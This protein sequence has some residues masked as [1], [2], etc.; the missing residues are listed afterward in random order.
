MPGIRERFLQFVAAGE[1]GCLLW[2]GRR[3]SKPN[4]DY[5]EFRHADGRREGAHRVAW[6]ISN[7]PI[8]DGLFVCHHC[9]NPPCVNPAHLFLGT[10]AD[11]MRDCFAKGRHV[12]PSPVEA[13]RRLSDTDVRDIRRAVSN[14]ARYGDLAKKYSVDSNTVKDAATGK[15][16]SQLDEPTAKAPR[17]GF[18][19]R[20]LEPGQAWCFKC[21]AA[22]PCADFAPTTAQR[23]AGWCRACSSS[24]YALRRRHA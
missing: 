22:K 7:G 5:G 4:F 19:K 18:R 14:G 13:I 17:K 20:K 11:N 12:V 21:K 8:P 16:W 24:Y 1:N 10:N 23:G 15:T 9:D 2:T 6:Q 3:Y